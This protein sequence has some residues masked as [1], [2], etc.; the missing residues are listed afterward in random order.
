MAILVAGA[1]LSAFAGSPLLVLFG[2]FIVG[3]GIGIDF[4]VS[5][6][7]VAETM[8]KSARSRMVVATIALQS[9]GM[10]LGAVAA[11]GTLHHWA[12]PTDWRLM[13]GASGVLGCLFL[14][15]RLTLPESPRWLVEHGR[16]AEAARVVVA[17]IGQTRLAVAAQATRCCRR[18]PQSRQLARACRPTSSRSSSRAPTGRAPCSR[19]C[20]GS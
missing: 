17:L 16:A 10:L 7:Y 20:R 5:A 2:Q 8:P 12:S 15:F 1:A 13:V 3:V 14:L 4:P 11:L 19:P 6:S 9:V 18:R